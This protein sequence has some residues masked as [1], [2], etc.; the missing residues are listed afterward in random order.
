MPAAPISGGARPATSQPRSTNPDLITK[1]NLASRITEA[2]SASSE[3]KGKKLAWSAKKEE[4][5]SLLQKRREEMI[6]AARRKMEEQDRAAAAM[7]S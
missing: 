2:P 5:Q 1:Y 6:L 7:K 3:D 4:R